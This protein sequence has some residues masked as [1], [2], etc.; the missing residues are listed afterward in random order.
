MDQPVCLQ[1]LQGGTQSF[2]GDPADILFH[3]IESHHTKFHQGI[4]DGHFVFS[5]DERK[6]ITE[7]RGSQ[8]FVGNTSCSHFTLSFR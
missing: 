8:A 5:V 4:E 3:L 6:G 2:V 1:L 7:S